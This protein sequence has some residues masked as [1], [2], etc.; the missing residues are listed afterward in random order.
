MRF[1]EVFKRLNGREATAEDVLK[2]ERLTTAL[3]TTPGDAML[4]V[5][6]ALDHYETLYEGIPAKI[7]Q[8]AKAS[9][10]NAAEQ[11]QSEVNS[12]VAKLVPSVEKAVK[13]GAAAAIGRHSLGQ[14]AITLCLSGLITG[15][16][17]GVGVIYGARIFGS[18]ASE[19]IAW[20]VFWKQISWSLGLGAA[21][22]GLILLG[23]ADFTGGDDRAWWQ[24]I[25]LALAFGTVCVLGY[26]L[27][28]SST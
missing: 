15:L 26:L 18:A 5:L 23:T 4:A 6:V 1:Q 28:T 12:A 25:A 19:H 14:S 9:A 8:A 3:E 13:A 16:V 7:Q 11:A 27:L 22:P 21:A 24:W 20:V 2:F 17:F 10:A